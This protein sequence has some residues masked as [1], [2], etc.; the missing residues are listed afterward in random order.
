MEIDEPTG[1]TIS[2]NLEIPTGQVVE[3]PG[4]NP[5]E[6]SSSARPKLKPPPKV[7]SKILNLIIKIQFVYI[8]TYTI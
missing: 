5:T 4:Q 8:L 6:H 3:N 2:K 7:V 1:S